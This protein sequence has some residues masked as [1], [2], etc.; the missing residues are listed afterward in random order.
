VADPA[1]IPT[2]LLSEFAK[3]KVTVVLTGEG[4]DELFAG[5][6]HYKIINATEKYLSKFPKC[7]LRKI[8]IVA[9][10]LPKNILNS[11]FSYTSA[12][13]KEGMRRFDKYIN[14]FGDLSKSYLSIISIFNHEELKDLLIKEQKYNVINFVDHFLKKPNLDTVNKLLL[15]ETKVQ[16]PDNLLMK[17]DK[18]TMAFSV[19]SRAPLLDHRLAEFVFK[20]PWNMKL[21]GFKDKYILRKVM[22]KFVP[23]E[24]VKRKKQRFFVPIDMWFQGELKEIFKQMF[25]KEEVKKRGYF[26]YNYIQKIFDN[27]EK[28]KLY[29]SRQLWNL[30]NFELWYRIFMDS[31]ARKPKLSFDKLL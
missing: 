24:I 17:V 1:A 14:S 30:L 2:Y 6:E 4:G 5:Y 9:N 18:M 28:S 8:P 26:K 7:M 22:R 29:Y 23:S 13:G 3:K 12:L 16:L 20:I 25:L 21:H 11:L 31:D 15:I 10:K 19:E 27:Y